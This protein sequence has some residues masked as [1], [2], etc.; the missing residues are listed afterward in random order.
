MDRYWKGETQN[1]ATKLDN[2]IK[3]ESIA[4]GCVFEIGEKLTF[5][6]EKWQ[7]WFSQLFPQKISYLR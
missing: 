7:C 2:R 4:Y 1:C 5:Y 6:E 3:N